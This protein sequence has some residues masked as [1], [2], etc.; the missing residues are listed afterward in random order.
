MP[1][2]IGDIASDAADDATQHRGLGGWKND[3]AKQQA[4]ISE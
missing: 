4:G 1:Y 2:L 3:A